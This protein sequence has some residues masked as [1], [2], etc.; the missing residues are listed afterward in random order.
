MVEAA[1][2]F[3]IKKKK[4]PCEIITKFLC[5]A[6]AFQKPF[7]PLGLQK[8]FPSKDHPFFSMGKGKQRKLDYDSSMKQRCMCIH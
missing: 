5:A 3:S 7:P 8:K 4:E 1:L 2:L 6:H